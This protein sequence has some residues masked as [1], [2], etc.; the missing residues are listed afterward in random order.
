[1][2]AS[3]SSSTLA[4][5]AHAHRSAGPLSGPFGGPADRR[6]WAH[7]FPREPRREAR[8]DRERDRDAPLPLPPHCKVLP[9]AL[10]TPRLHRTHN[11]DILH[12]GGTLTGRRPTPNTQ[13]RQPL[14]VKTNP[15]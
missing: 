6:R 10:P 2:G 12:S 9:A 1:M 13:V 8:R 14:T 3:Q 7:S 4:S 15:Y 11:G 5:A